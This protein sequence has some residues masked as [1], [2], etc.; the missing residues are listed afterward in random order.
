MEAEIFPLPKAFLFVSLITLAF[1]ATH[2]PSRF[3]FLLTFSPYLLSFYSSCAAFLCSPVLLPFSPSPQLSP[4]VAFTHHFLRPS[5]VSA[6]GT[7]G[8]IGSVL[9]LRKFTI[10]WSHCRTVPESIWGHMM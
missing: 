10:L 1:I 7:E 8:L 5:Y 3:A 9:A 4:G 6:V 2:F